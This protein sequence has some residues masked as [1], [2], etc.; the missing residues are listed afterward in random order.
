MSYEITVRLFLI[1]PFQTP[2]EI[3][4]AYNE[5]PRNV[6]F[7]TNLFWERY[8]ATIKWRTLIHIIPLI[9][10]LFIKHFMTKAKKLM[11]GFFSH[12]VEYKTA[13]DAYFNAI[14]T[15]LIPLS[16]DIRDPISPAGRFRFIVLQRL[17]LGHVGLPLYTPTFVNVAIQCLA[18]VKT[19]LTEVRFNFRLWSS[20]DELTRAA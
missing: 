10:N 17:D 19:L 3:F 1:K 2:I 13:F 18:R 16:D 11:D 14:M 12:S 6:I 7:Q 5:T 15:L 9:D 20:H 4:D 8:R